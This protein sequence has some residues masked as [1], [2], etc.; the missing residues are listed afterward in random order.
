MPVFHSTTKSSS[1]K[2]GL[3]LSLSISFSLS[4]ANSFAED[5]LDSMS[6]AMIYNNRA[7]AEVNTHNYTEAI[8]DF[9]KAIA[10]APKMGVVYNNRGLA[11]YSMKDYTGAIKD[12]D[13]SLKLDPDKAYTYSNRGLSYYNL[14]IR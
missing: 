3:F 13:E 8:A 10:L 6:K 9:D 1:F 14:V 7:L 5:S 2:L 4:S 12:Y 11:R